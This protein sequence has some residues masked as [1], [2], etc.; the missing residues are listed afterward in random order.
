VLPCI[1][2]LVAAAVLYRFFIQ[3]PSLPRS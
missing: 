3:T 2:K 1:L